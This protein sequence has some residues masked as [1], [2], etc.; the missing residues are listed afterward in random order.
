[1][2]RRL[3]KYCPDLGQHLQSLE[4]TGKVTVDLAYKP[5]TTKP[6]QHDI[7]SELAN[8]RFRHPRVPMDWEQIT[9]K[10]R[11]TDGHLTLEEG[12]AQCGSARI[13]VSTAWANLPDLAQDFELAMAVEQLQVDPANFGCLPEG[14]RKTLELFQPAGP[15]NID[16]ALS[17]R[18]GVWQERRLVVRPQGASAKYRIFPFAVERI[19][20]R[21]DIDLLAH[22]LKVDLKGYSGTQALVV[23]GTWKGVADQADADLNIKAENLPVDEKL[24]SALPEASQKLARS[25][26]PGGRADIEA[27]VRHL[28]GK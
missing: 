19:G 12:A 15:V 28:P 9:L 26:H 11:C 7:R 10:L 22:H 24:L 21:L 25:F 6:W 27:K 3:A 4:G 14:V 20:G 1:L 23:R 16:A 5:G 18:K 13:K 8:G 2:L 17:C